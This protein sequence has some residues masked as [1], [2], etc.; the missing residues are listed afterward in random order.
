[1]GFI[2]AVR[3]CLRR[4]AV[5]RGRAPRA[6]FWCFFLFTTVLS[7]AVLPLEGVLREEMVEGIDLAISLAFLSPSLAVT[8]RR[9][10]DRDRTG[11]WA[12]LFA[13]ITWFGFFPPQHGDPMAVLLYPGLIALLAG[14]IMLVSPGSEGANRFGPDPL[15]APAE[16]V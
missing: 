10:H 14:L 11:W 15:A 3:L 7:F 13:P 2:A 6:E 1:M 8:I 5:F 16:D 4:Y 9:L 12:L